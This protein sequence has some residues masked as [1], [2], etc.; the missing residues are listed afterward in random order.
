[1]ALVPGSGIAR[2]E[3]GT[4]Q[5]VEAQIARD[6]SSFFDLY[7]HLHT[8]PE[9]SFQ[10]EKTSARVA[11]A[12]RNAGYE[13]TTGVGRYGVVGILRNKS[14]PTVLIRTDMDGLPVKEQT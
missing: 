8:H 11:E 12:L 4:H 13:V 1:M 6:Y 7:K 14:G 2:D 9:L 5:A 10:E 3:S